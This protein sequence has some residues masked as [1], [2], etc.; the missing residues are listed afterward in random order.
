[1]KRIMLIT[2]ALLATAPLPAYA[3]KGHVWQTHAGLDCLEFI[4][5][6]DAVAACPGHPGTANGSLNADGTINNECLAGA[7]WYGVNLG[8]GPAQNGFPADPL[9]SLAQMVPQAALAAAVLNAQAQAQQ[10][11]ILRR[12]ETGNPNL[13]LLDLGSVGKVGFYVAT[14]STPISCRD[15]SNNQLPHLVPPVD[16]VNYPA[17][18]IQ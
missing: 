14:P 16:N 8:Y 15:L 13:G 6:E 11:V 5:I 9:L 2:A 10:E 1:M 4:L 7:Q 17:D 18:S 3:I 12:I